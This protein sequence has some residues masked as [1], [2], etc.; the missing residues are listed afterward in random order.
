MIYQFIDAHRLEYP[1]TRLCQ[2]LGVADGGYDKRAVY[3]GLRARAPGAAILIPSRH[4]ARIWRHSNTQAPPHP[5]DEILCF[6]C[7]HGRQKW[8]EEY[9]CLSPDSCTKA[10]DNC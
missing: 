9:C 6:I 10:N 3:D 2:T 8:K 5:R 1:V 4:N 7:I